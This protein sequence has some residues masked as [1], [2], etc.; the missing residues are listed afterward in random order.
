MTEQTAARDAL[1]S[2]LSA[3]AAVA[4]PAALRAA[5]HQLVDA[6]DHDDRAAPQAE[7]RTPPEADAT[8]GVVARQNSSRAQDLSGLETPQRAGRPVRRLPALKPTPGRVNGKTAGPAFTAEWL[9][10]RKQVRTAMA[11]RH[12]DMAGL[13]A[14]ID[15]NGSTV[16]NVMTKRS[17]PSTPIANLLREF[18]LSGPGTP[19]AGEA[20]GGSNG[21]AAPPTP[22]EPVQAPANGAVPLEPAALKALKAKRHATPLTQ[23]TLAGQLGLAD[24]ELARAL[25]GEAIS[26]AAVSTLTAWAAA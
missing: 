20:P 5:V 25:A 9:H 6:Q 3:L 21:G 19:P 1:L 15:R 17:A 12:L 24:G 14:A 8:D 7:T 2:A 26:A 11:Q 23:H 16:T 4:A 18:L 22:P 10:L 13:A